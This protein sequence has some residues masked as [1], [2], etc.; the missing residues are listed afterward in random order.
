MT[1]LVQLD[2][3]FAL[4]TLLTVQ[5]ARLAI[6]VPVGMATATLARAAR[7][8]E[9]MRVC[10]VCV[11]CDT[12]RPRRRNQRNVRSGKASP[13]RDEASQPKPTAFFI[14]L[15][16]C[17][18]CSLQ[19]FDVAR[20]GIVYCDRGRQAVRSVVRVAVS[21]KLGVAKSGGLNAIMQRV[22][23]GAGGAGRAKPATTGAGA[24]ESHT[25]RH[26]QPGKSVLPELRFQIPEVAGVM[27][28]QRS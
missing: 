9:I 12:K 13:G 15:S 3:D 10:I 27:R 2:S 5:V 7:T 26:V 23:G 25:A 28:E 22:P 16:A 24:C 17:S 21:G 14:V 11:R 4:E 8:K 1:T 19:S 6:S 18:R 20:R